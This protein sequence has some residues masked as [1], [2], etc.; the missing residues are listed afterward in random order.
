MNRDMTP[1]PPE[2]GQEPTEQLFRDVFG[3]A[4]ETARRITDA[5]VD[6]RLGR[7][8]RKTGHAAPPAPEP[9][10]ASALDDARRQAGEIVAD[11]QRAAA[12]TAAEAAC[13]AQ[14]AEEAARRQA[15]R[16]IAEAEEYSDTAL[17]S[18]AAIIASARS[19]A[20]SII[21]DAEKQAG[22]IIAAAR[23]RAD[24]RERQLALTGTRARDPSDDQTPAATLLAVIYCGT[25]GAEPAES[26]DQLPLPLA[27]LGIR[28]WRDVFSMDAAQERET[29]RRVLRSWKSV[30]SRRQP[31]L[32]SAAAGCLACA[33]A[34]GIVTSVYIVH[35]PDDDAHVADLRARL[36]GFC[37]IEANQ[38][39][40]QPPSQDGEPAITCR[41]GAARSIEASY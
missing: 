22:Q 6:A 35:A 13:A 16:V 21:A 2:G 9:D 29:P 14:A 24:S 19:Q 20:E 37:Q 12:E 33:S 3:L 30:R 34:D 7:L 11:A 4:D 26:N 23:V 27:A 5:E 31:R 32:S 17:N 1:G 41:N 10:P 38:A 18:A 39:E 28:T 25:A 40:Q 8:L 36:S 15:G